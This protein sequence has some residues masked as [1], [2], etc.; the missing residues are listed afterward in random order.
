MCIRDRDK[1]LI[2]MEADQITG[3]ELYSREG[4]AVVVKNESGDSYQAWQ[5]TE[6]YQKD[7]YQQSWTEEI[8][9]PLSLSL[10]HI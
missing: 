1:A 10:I 3:L 4:Q 7:V 9:T 6:P 5:M 2:L 8:L